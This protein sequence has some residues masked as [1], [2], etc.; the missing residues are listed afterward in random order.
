[1]AKK[2]EKII[3]EQFQTWSH[4]HAL[5]GS[6]ARKKKTKPVI[7]ISREFGARGAAL[8]HNLEKKIGF[9]V[10]DKDL[11]Q[12][13]AKEI[14]SGSRA[15]ETLDERRQQMVE[16]T[17]T[18]FLVNIPTNMNYLRSLIRVVKAIEG[19]GNG[20]IVGRGS[21]YI[22]QDPKSLH[23][24]VVCPLNVRIA[25]YAKKENIPQHEARLIIEQKEREREEFVKQ[26]FYRDASNA[27]D[28]DLLLNSDTF[29]M[30]QMSMIIIA[31]Y[32]E[33]TGNKLNLVEA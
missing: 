28:Y 30:D 17:V 1:M 22:I 6:R 9:K 13:I 3:E 16:D 29:T 26:N 5:A 15:V 11:I 12:A 7:T 33:K 27:S 14:G 19:Y 18:G 25:Q 23:V 24:R 10:W 21:N 2:I 31:A 20:I 8:A 32:E 4:S